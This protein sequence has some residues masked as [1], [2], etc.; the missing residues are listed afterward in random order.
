MRS[1]PLLPAVVLLALFMLGPAIWSLYGSL[2]NASLTGKAALNPRFIGVKNYTD[3]MADPEFWKSIGLTVLF[4]LASAVVG[5]NVLGLAIALLQ[6]SAHSVV[7]ALVGTI[8]VGAWV[9]PEIVAAFALYAFFADDG[10]L[11]SVLGMINIPVVHWLYEHPMLSVILANVWRGTAFSMMVYG[12]ALTEVPPEI[13]EAAEV[14]GAS[15]WQRLAHI[16]LPMITRSIAT[17]L[18]LTTLQTL[19]VFTLIYVMTAGGPGTDSSTLPVLAYQVA[20]QFAKVG[21]GTAIATFM[22][23][24]GAV[25]SIIYIRMLKPEVDA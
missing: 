23:L 15:G 3:L 25:F 11:N 5:Q 8:V 1:V 20:F 16:T 7:R 22:L 12:A 13:E 14:D 18:M 19:S 6:K 10:T 21:Y 4:T 2:T 9:L 24:I 17:N